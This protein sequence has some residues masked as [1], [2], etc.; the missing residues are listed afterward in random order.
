MDRPRH[1]PRFAVSIVFLVACFVGSACS[2]SPQ[3]LEVS[4]SSHPSA[5]LVFPASL[6]FDVPGESFEFIARVQDQYGHAVG[7]IQIRWETSDKAVVSVTSTGLVTAMSPGEATVT[8][9]VTDGSL[10]ATSRVVV[11]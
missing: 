5:I 3:T 8:V 2:E 9:S 1:L 7:G 4:T 11:N 6:T 10:K